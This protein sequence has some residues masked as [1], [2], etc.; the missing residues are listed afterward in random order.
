M[1]PSMS[2]SDA[3]VIW[4][5]RIA[6]NAPIMLARTAIHAV[7]LALSALLG[8]E[9]LGL[10]ARWLGRLTR[11]D[12]MAMA[13]LDMTTPPLTH[14]CAPVPTRCALAAAWWRWSGRP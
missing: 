1:P 3:L 5:L 4:M 13:V 2:S 7:R 12:A 11:G 8:F 9:A 14:L 10:E 6:M